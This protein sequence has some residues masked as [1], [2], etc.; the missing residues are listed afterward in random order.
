MAG[1]ERE[2]AAV[3]SSID[4]LRESQRQARQMGAFT[5]DYVLTGRTPEKISD[6]GEWLARARSVAGARVLLQ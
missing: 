2:L 4:L 5:L 3:G 1:L 6:F